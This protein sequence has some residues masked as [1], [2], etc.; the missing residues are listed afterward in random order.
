MLAAQLLREARRSHSAPARPGSATTRCA[1][2]LRAVLVASLAAAAAGSWLM[3]PSAAG[4]ATGD[5]VAR[6][7][8]TGIVSPA[9]PWGGSVLAVRPGQTV[10]FTAGTIPALDDLHLGKPLGYR[11]TMSTAGLPGGAHDVHLSTSSTYPVRFADPGVY[12]LRWTATS[13]LGGVALNLNQLHSL[14]IDLNA[15]EQWSAQVVVSDHPTKQPLSLALP[16]ISVDAHLPVLGH[17]ITLRIPSLVLAPGKVP[18]PPGGGGGSNPPPSSGGGGQSPGGSS[19]GGAGGGGTPPNAAGLPN[20]A[21]QPPAAQS[22]PG[23]A[24]APSAHPHHA[25]GST[26]GSISTYALPILIGVLIL[27]VLWMAWV[28]SI[29]PILGR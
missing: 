25:S 28:A 3:S 12:S 24:A 16:A 23:T 4:A 19:S 13:L 18:P 26:L 8:L 2:S 14:G 10:L 22:G 27:G 9:S 11:V 7:S 5:V 29:K 15:A 6:L 17:V 21:E 1:S 20:A